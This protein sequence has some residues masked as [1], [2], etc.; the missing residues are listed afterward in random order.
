MAVSDIPLNEH[1]IRSCSGF[2][3]ITALSDGRP[4]TYKNWSSDNLKRTCKAVSDGM[5][6]RRAAEEYAIP[7]STIYD[8]FSGRVLFGS[9]SG[10]KPYL[11]TTEEHELVNFLSGMSSVGY[12]RTVKE[13]IE[14]VQAVVDEKKL[15]VTVSSSWWKSFKS[16]HKHLVLRAPESLTHSR[17]QGVSEELIE[18]YFD[19]LETT[20][21]EAEL[22]ERPCQLF[23]L[24]ES[25]FPLSIKPTKVISEKGYKH[26]SSI[27][28]QER[29]QITVLGCC[30]AGGY[31]IP[32][33]VIFDRKVLKPELA[34]GEVPG[35]MYGLTQNGWI[36]REVFESWFSNHFLV[37]APPARPLLLLMDGHSSHFSP[38]FVNKAAEE[39]VIVF[40][41]LPNGTHRT[42]PLDKGVFSPLKKAWKEECHAYMLKNPGK[43][44]TRFQFSQLFG[45]AW[46]KAMSQTNIVAGFRVTGVYP[47]DRYKILTKRKSQPSTICQKTGL[48]FIPL[49]TPIRRKSKFSPVISS[50]TSL[51]SDSDS[52]S[53][54]QPFTNE[55]IELFTRRKEEGYD[56]LTDSTYNLWKSLQ[57]KEE[58]INPPQ[59][60]TALNKVLGA[61]PPPTIK[62]PSFLSKTTSCVVTSEECRQNIMEKEKKK[63]EALKLK[64][65]RK[66]L[67]EIRQEE[68]RKKLQD[69]F[70][71]KKGTNKVDFS[72]RGHGTRVN[73]KR[74]NR[75]F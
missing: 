2:I 73:S 32:P 6:I 16:R 64:E 40:C 31:A 50:S 38:V 57:D 66:L 46:M 27:T 1:V 17:I 44:V 11:T 51:C 48:K 42:Q 52:T 45:Q 19:L 5:S 68:R 63:I 60:N 61:Q 39:K 55:E 13:V 20:L 59:P 24:D 49:I 22:L 47:V 23:N 3:D 36:N 54:Q 56:I 58:I 33:L 34:I 21:E 67:R 72:S 18:N 74:R 7:K 65:E 28:S 12:S 26:P 37:Y 41:L 69:K 4:C 35:T 10:P 9:K 75:I 43:N 8:H 14:I 53:D 70:K 29:T 15:G 71:D 62:N 25:G 30:S